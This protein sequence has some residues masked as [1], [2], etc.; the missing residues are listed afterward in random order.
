MNVKLVWTFKQNQMRTEM[1]S[2]N[3]RC[4]RRAPR[5]PVAVTCPYRGTVSNLSCVE[6][7]DHCVC[8]QKSCD[9][10]AKHP[11]RLTEHTAHH[12]TLTVIVWFYFHVDPNYLFLCYTQIHLNKSPDPTLPWMSS[13]CIIGLWTG[14]ILSPDVATNAVAFVASRSVSA[15]WSLLRRG[16]SGS[17]RRRQ[18]SVLIL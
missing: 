11:N 5:N 4:P 13:C 6:R 15:N 12:N 2:Q 10:I 14:S 17:A 18:A 9:H 8:C 7:E 3:P 1:K 16:P